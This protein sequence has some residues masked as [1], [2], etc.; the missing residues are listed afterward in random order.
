MNAAVLK[1]TVKKA[2]QVN[3]SLLIVGPPGS[4]KTSI[5]KD[6]EDSNIDLAVFHPSVGEPTDIKGFPWCYQNPKTGTREAEFV[7]Y[8]EMSRLLS[9]TKKTIALFDDIGQA[10]EDM[11]AALMQVLWARELNGHKIS[12]NITFIGCTNDIKDKA[13]VQGM[14]EPL[15][16]RWHSIIRYSPTTDD[17]CNWAYNNNMP[18]SLID[19][20]RFRPSLMFEFHPTKEIKNGPCPRT[21]ANF[22][23]ILNAN[24]P[25]EAEYE[26]GI[27]AVGEGYTA[28]YFAYKEV[29]TSLPTYEEIVADPKNAPL[30]TKDEP[31]KLFAICGFLSRATDL[32]TLANF[33]KIMSYVQRMDIEFLLIYIKD[34][35]S[36]DTNRALIRNP[37]YK[38]WLKANANLLV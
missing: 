32:K 31:S 10:T 11:Q 26:L 33:E 27:G 37:I 17:W 22:G 19:F 13:C 7:V 30:P 21:I 5:I 3:H 2:L 28:E 14:I 9:P 25:K 8:G 36:R 18:G 6:F 24:Y 35:R 12:R 29:Y 23:E 15:K 34:V 38:D 4:G 20:N 1:E 16:S